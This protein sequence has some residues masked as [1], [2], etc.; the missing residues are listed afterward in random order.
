MILWSGLLKCVFVHITL[1]VGFKENYEL[2]VEKDL[3]IDGVHFVWPK[4]VWLLS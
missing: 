3:S 1:S 2:G 4:W